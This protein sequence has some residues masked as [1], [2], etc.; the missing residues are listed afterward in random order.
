MIEE[1]S[2]LFLVFVFVLI[3]IFFSYLYYNKIKYATK[4]YDASKEIIRAIVLNFKS[5]LNKSNKKIDDVVFNIEGIQSVIHK[6]EKEYHLLNN[7]ANILTKKLTTFYKIN[8]TITNTIIS[9]KKR[10]NELTAT[11]NALNKKIEVIKTKYHDYLNK[12]DLSKKPIKKPTL[13]NITNTEKKII[14]TLLSEGSKTAPEIEKIIEK[15]R[16]HTSRLMKKL[17]VEGYIE[18]ETHVIPFIYRPTKELKKRIN[19]ER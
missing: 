16:E 15:T 4:E 6:L 17:W 9:N 18:R 3:T 7:K 12:P 19:I 1:F 10:I 13:I 5:K 14:N 11:K 8:K 2:L